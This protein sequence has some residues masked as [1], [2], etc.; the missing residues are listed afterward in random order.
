M[1]LAVLPLTP[2]AKYIVGVLVIY[3]V[4]GA[5]GRPVA[6]SDL[7]PKEVGLEERS[8]YSFSIRQGK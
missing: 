3:G 2:S 7:G 5:R 8:Q 1:G 4:S 6:Y